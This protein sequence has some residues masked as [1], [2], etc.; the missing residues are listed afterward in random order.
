VIVADEDGADGQLWVYTGLK[1]YR[2]TAFDKAGL[3]AGSSHV[4]R[5]GDWPRTDPSSR[6]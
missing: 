6:P 2:G 1:Q 5:V 3:T 4:A